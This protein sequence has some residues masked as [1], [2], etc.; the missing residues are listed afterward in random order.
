MNLSIVTAIQ[1]RQLIKLD[2]APGE[3]LVEPH[4]YGRNVHGNELLRAFQVS[5]ASASG[6]HR[7]WKLFR[8]DRI[9][10][11]IVLEEK[12]DEPRPGYRR[13]DSAMEEE[14]FSQ[15]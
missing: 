15:L 6:E 7:D 14:I 4:A 2:Y 5:G 10:S 8:V 9:D 13:G 11:L 12:F 3:R 1:E